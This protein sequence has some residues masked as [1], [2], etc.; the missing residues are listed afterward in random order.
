MCVHNLILLLLYYVILLSLVSTTF[1]LLPYSY[2]YWFFNLGFYPL[3]LAFY[4][5]VKSG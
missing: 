3:Y 5:L 2:V 4:L 1:I